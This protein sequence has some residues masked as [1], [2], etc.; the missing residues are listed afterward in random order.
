MSRRW[1]EERGGWRLSVTIGSE[2][3]E[4]NNAWEIPYWGNVRLDQRDDFY[5]AGSIAEHYI[6][7]GNGNINIFGYIHYHLKQILSGIIFLKDI[8]DSSFRPSLVS[9]GWAE[10]CDILTCHYN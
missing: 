4:D 10:I 8:K 3:M 7:P 5:L 9:A 6:I 1:S 2:S